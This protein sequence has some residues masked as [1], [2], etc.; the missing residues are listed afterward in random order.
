MLRPKRYFISTSNVI[1]K[2]RLLGNNG[3]T[4]LKKSDGFRI[5][6]FEVKSA[7]LGRFIVDFLIVIAVELDIPLLLVSNDNNKF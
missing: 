1:S 2:D 3:K 7:E 5:M 4:F 6:I